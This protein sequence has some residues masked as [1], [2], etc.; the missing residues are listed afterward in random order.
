MFEGKRVLITGG[1]GSLGRAITKRLLNFEVESIRI[2][3]RNEKNQVIMQEEFNDDSRLRFFIGDVRDKERLLRAM[4]GV[5]IVFHTAA[6]KHVPKIEY[7]PFEAI[8][9]NVMGSQNVIDCCHKEG[10]DMVIGVGTDKAVSPLNVYGATKLLMEKLFT[11]A[12]NYVDKQ[13]HPT[14]FISTRYG[15]VLGS[16]GSVV[17]K[18]I[19]QIRTKGKITITDPAMTRFTILMDE[20]LDF[21][22]NSIKIGKSS[23]IFI[24]K[25]SAYNIM[26]LKDALIELFGTVE[27]EYRS[28][29]HGEKLHEVLIN[30]DEIRNTLENK[31][32]YIVTDP[33]ISEKQISEMFPDYKNVT[34]MEDYSSNNVKKLSKNELKELINKA[35]LIPDKNEFKNLN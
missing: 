11:S 29:R 22:F 26:D 4:E 15:N 7:N 31:D 33:Q 34:N 14:R 6:L 24:P 20:A 13:K 9:T 21:I 2:F 28:I 17:P 10:V 12:G 19:N 35:N 27:I 23:E 8:Q 25:L 32:H 30:A 16:S 1:T 3:S 5:D 18:F